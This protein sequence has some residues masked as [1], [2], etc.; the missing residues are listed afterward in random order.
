MSFQ[1]RSKNGAVEEHVWRRSLVWSSDVSQS[2][3]TSRH[4]CSFSRQRTFA[5]K[6]SRVEEHSG[7]RALHPDLQNSRCPDIRTST[8]VCACHGLAVLSPAGCVCIAGRRKDGQTL[9]VLTFHRLDRS[10]RPFSGRQCMCCR[11][12]K[13][14]PDTLCQTPL[15][16]SSR[17][18]SAC[19]MHRYLD[20]DEGTTTMVWPSSLRPAMYVLPAGER[21]DRHSLSD[22][23]PRVSVWPSFLRPAIHT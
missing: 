23:L 22:L 4:D 7:V 3:C 14:R 8:P 18:L 10:G 11:P 12:E 16:Q 19:Y 1:L 21:M 13:G 2:E 6:N 15:R 5:S 20:N 17:S 9:F